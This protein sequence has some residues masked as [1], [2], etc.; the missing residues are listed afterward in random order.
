MAKPV[1]LRRSSNLM[2]LVLTRAKC[3]GRTCFVH[4]SESGV[5]GRQRGQKSLIDIRMAFILHRIA[6]SWRIFGDYRQ[7]L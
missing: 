3:R 6:V 4:Q 1:D 2:F 5:P 7:G